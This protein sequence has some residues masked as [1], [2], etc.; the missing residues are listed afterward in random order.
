M[1]V[2]PAVDGLVPPTTFDIIKGDHRMTNASRPAPLDPLLASLRM[3]P[4]GV[5]YLGSVQDLTGVDTFAAGAD[6]QAEGA[7]RGE[8]LTEEALS[9]EVAASEWRP[10]TAHFPAAVRRVMF[11]DGSRRIE[12]RTYLEG[13]PT[14]FG[15]LGSC[16]VGAVVCDAPG[17][18]L[19]SGPAVMTARFVGEP[20]VQRWLALSRGRPELG[21]R[22]LTIG[23]GAQAASYHVTIDD[24]EG[25]AAADDTD[26]PVRV[27]NDRMQEAE[28]A[29]ATSLLADLGDGL[30]LCDGT[31]PRVGPDTRVLGYVK[32]VQAQRLPATALNVVRALKEGER[33]PLY[34][35]GQG[36][37]A[38]FEWYLRLRD[39][40]PWLHTLAGSV[41]LQAHAG[42]DPRAQLGRAR[43]LADWSCLTLPRFATHS[44]QDPRAPQQLLPVRALEQSLRRR[45]GSAPLLRRRM[46]ASLAAGL[47]A[48]PARGT[49]EL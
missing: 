20:I 49:G 34:V 28:R 43:G 1:P 18:S 40:G 4:W 5:D 36:M 25:G 48:A 10:V 44:H 9:V 24:S 7:G 32:T 30:L 12:A 16:A 46:I 39:P 27:L 33:S 41:R 35:V 15:A 21:G 26:A 42:P 31:R 13:A 11:L 3:E 47:S 14:L 23:T 37:F 8:Q 38:R 6:Q 19:A 45:L 2:V 29:L 22:S 17:A